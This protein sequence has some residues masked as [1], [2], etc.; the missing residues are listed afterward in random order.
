MTKDVD[1][2]LCV[3]CSYYHERSTKK[4]PQ[5]NWKVDVLLSKGVVRG[6]Y[7][8]EQKFILFPKTWTHFCHAHF[9]AETPK[10]SKCSV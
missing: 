1:F 9:Q 6:I 4:E 3:F 8:F 7:K 10:I 2:P 5:A